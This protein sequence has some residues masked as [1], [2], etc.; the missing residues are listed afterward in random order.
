MTQHFQIARISSVQFLVRRLPMCSLSLSFKNNFNNNLA[1][2]ESEK[3]TISTLRLERVTPFSD[4]NDIE[5]LEMM[6]EEEEKARH[7]NI[8]NEI[9][10]LFLK[11]NDPFAVAEL[12]HLFLAALTLKSAM[13]QRSAKSSGSSVLG[14]SAYIAAGKSRSEN[15]S[16][17]SILQMMS[18]RGPKINLSTKTEM[19][20]RAFEDRQAAMAAFKKKAHA[21]R[22]RL[23]CELEEFNQREDDITDSMA[24]FEYNIVAQ[25]VDPLTQRIPAEK[26]LNYMYAWLKNSMQ[27]IEK[28]RLRTSS[29]RLQHSKTKSLLAQ[30]KELSLNVTAVDFDRLEIENKHFQKK[31]EQKNEHL[32]QLK[33]MTAGINLVITQHRKYMQG[34]T[35]YF[36]KIRNDVKKINKRTDEINWEADHVQSELDKAEET[37]DYFLGL[38]KS[39]KVPDVMEYVKLKGELREVQKSIKIWKRKKYIQDL[40]MDAALREMKHLTGSKRVDKNWLR[41]PEEVLGYNINTQN[42][43]PD[44]TTLCL[45]PEKYDKNS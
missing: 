22:R 40:A 17:A 15:A 44:L 26:F 23:K 36:T 45:N 35:D 16:S 31:I 29:M 21:T 2:L 10:T 37:Y 3:V 8:E 41:D 1:N 13:S 11:E 28:M 20:V 12:E 43:V 6:Y 39:Y 25:G 30:R 7:L 9:F 34:Q 18:S 42:S 14:S 38:Q 19:V 33:K 5:F 27:N 4:L 24:A 32:F